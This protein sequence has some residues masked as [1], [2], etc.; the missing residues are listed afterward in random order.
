MIKDEVKTICQK[1]KAASYE[2]SNLS[3]QIKNSIL[4]RASELI[5]ENIDNIILENDK[6]IKTAKDN[7]LEAAKIDRLKLDKS[8][9]EGIAGSITDIINLADPIGEIT[10]EA[11][12]PSGID[13]KR[14]R[15]AIGVLLTIYESRPNV[16]SD[17]SALCL[18]SGNVAILRCGSDS[19]NSSTIIANLYRK[20]L[21]EHGLDENIVTLIS[22]TNRE[23][24]SE[25]LKQ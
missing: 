8:R 19:I 7:N 13:I 12:R 1:S 4:K 17:V 5:I 11:T 21:K 10:Y 25:L 16:T 15:T 3:T 20:S 23:Y 9:I 24:V 18:K 6:D 14:V 22:N 2:I